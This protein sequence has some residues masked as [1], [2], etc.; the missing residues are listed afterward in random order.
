MPKISIKSKNPALSMHKNTLIIFVMVLGSIGLIYGIWWYFMNLQIEDEQ[1]QIISGRANVVRLVSTTLETKFSEKIKILEIE[2][3]LPSVQNVAY[4][5]YINASIKGIPDNMDVEK[6]KTAQRI[7][8]FDKDF[9]VVFFAMPNGDMYMQE[10]YSDQINNKVLNFAFRDWY[11]GTIDTHQTYVSEAYL[12]QATGKKAVAISEPLHYANGTLMGMWVGLIDLDSLENKISSLDLSHNK[13]IIITDQNGRS[14]IDTS[15]THNTSDLLPYTTIESVR[16]ALSGKS[17]SIVEMVNGTRMFSVYQ[18]VQIGTNTW[19]VVLMQPY[20]DAF[21]IISSSTESSYLTIFLIT[22]V[23]AIS[24]FFAYKLMRSNEV[25]AKKLMEADLAKDEFSAMITHEL[26]TPLVTINGYSEMLEGEILGPLNEKQVDAIRE[27][28]SGSQ[29]LECLISDIKDAKKLDLRKMRFRKEDFPVD[30]LMTLVFANN[31]QLMK[32]K[33]I[34]FTN[35][36]KIKNVIHS[37]KNRL[38][39]V[40]SNLIKN[41]VDFVPDARGKIEIGAE[42]D[43]KNI[44]FSVKDNGVG[45]P[46][47]KQENLFSK[48]YQIDT[49]LK[50][51]HGGTGLGLV[52]CKGIVETLGG[53]IWFKSEPEKGT[54]FCFSIPINS[55]ENPRG[56][57]SD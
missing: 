2:G 47:E 46:V 28:Y 29:R 53:K 51:K 25:L 57:W 56:S 42:V 11:K 35:S 55:S 49:T 12:S 16:N 1:N 40:F 48:F 18:P 41:S 39:Q 19:S 52:I 50:R 17:G 23:I 22:L 10:P 20:D 27:I 44:V 9:N 15:N 21:G 33:N 6:R 14:V 30:Q 54:T 43:G 7:L 5:N 24:G 36:T 13:R 4:A 8:A 37:D 3:D 34:N 32:S 26:K 38:E 31:V 45:I